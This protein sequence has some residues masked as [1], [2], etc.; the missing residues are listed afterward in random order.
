MQLST[1]YLTLQRAVETHRHLTRE[2]AT[3]RG[4]DRHLL[5]LRSMLQPQDREHALLFEDDIFERSQQW[6]LST[7]GLSAGH[8]FKGTGCVTTYVQLI[9][10]IKHVVQHSFGAMYNDGYGINCMFFVSMS[11]FYQRMMEFCVDL[12][13]P[14]MIKFGI[15]SKFS[16][17]HTSTTS[18]KKA[19]SHS[20]EEMQTICLAPEVLTTHN[21][22][23]HL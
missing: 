20:L 9:Q 16:S 2:A 19:I 4:I 14:D 6:K 5:G 23:T 15:E 22:V 10:C 18:L 17:P 7:S 12:A 21:I 1:R 8:L 13:A 3:G 11:M